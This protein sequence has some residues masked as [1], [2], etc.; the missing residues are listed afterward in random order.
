MPL[1]G[2]FIG[3][4]Y[5]KKKMTFYVDTGIDEKLN[6][7][8]YKMYTLTGQKHTKTSII[9]MLLEALLNE[10]KNQSTGENS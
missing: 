1:W 4:I 2:T 5:L 10:D 8:L 3:D 9:H 7:W 6:H